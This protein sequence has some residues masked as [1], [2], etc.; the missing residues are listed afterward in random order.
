MDK[1]SEDTLL[2]GDLIVYKKRKLRDIKK[3]II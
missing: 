2:K 1:K 3:G